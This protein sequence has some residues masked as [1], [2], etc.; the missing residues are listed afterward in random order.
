LVALVF[1]CLASRKQDTATVP[2]PSL[3]E[4]IPA[5]I[6]TPSEC[7]DDEL[8]L[9]LELDIGNVVSISTMCV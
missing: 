3:S 1:F 6:K 4:N 7:L 5:K 9:D 8:D 2:V